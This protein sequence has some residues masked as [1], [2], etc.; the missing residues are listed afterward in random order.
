MLE[1]LRVPFLAVFGSEDTV[2]PV[3]KSVR[4]LRA[5]AEASGNGAVTVRA[6]PGGDHGLQRRE[7]G[8]GRSFVPGYFE[9]LE[10]WMRSRGGLR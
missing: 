4:V 1:K 7:P 10:Q 3:E 8:G 5:A 6:F 2:V 9:L